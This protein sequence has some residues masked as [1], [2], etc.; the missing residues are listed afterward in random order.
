MSA[1]IYGVLYVSKASGKDLRRVLDSPEVHRQGRLYDGQALYRV[2]SRD[3]GWEEP[4]PGSPED[5]S[6]IMVW[7]QDYHE[8]I[9]V[10]VPEGH[11]AGGLFLLWGEDEPEPHEALI[12]DIGSDRPY[13]PTSETIEMLFNEI[14]NGWF[15]P[16]AVLELSSFYNNREDQ[17]QHE[18]QCGVVLGAA[19]LREVLTRVREDITGEDAGFGLLGDDGDWSASYDEERRTAFLSWRQHGTDLCFGFEI[20]PADKD[21]ALKLLAE[22]FLKPFPGSLDTPEGMSVNLQGHTQCVLAVRPDPRGGFALTARHGNGVLHELRTDDL[23]VRDISNLN[24][25]IINY[26]WKQ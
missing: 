21:A 22:K 16:D 14:P 2:L 15:A 7:S 26:R 13:D 25:A 23:G 4:L 17:G 5:A 18:C 10:T 8:I 11:G 6:G 20:R 24:N 9:P 12:L 1:T 3:Y 19:T